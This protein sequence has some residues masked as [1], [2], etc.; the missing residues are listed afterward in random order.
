MIKVMRD[1]G[2]DAAIILLVLKDIIQEL[3]IEEAMHFQKYKQQAE[4]AEEEA[5]GGD[6]T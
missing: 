5:K 3:A 1:S 2:L 4:K 6:K